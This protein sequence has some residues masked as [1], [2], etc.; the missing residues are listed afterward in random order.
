MFK[1]KSTVISLCVRRLHKRFCG[2]FGYPCSYNVLKIYNSRLY[3]VSIL[4]IYYRKYLKL[5]KFQGF[6]SLA[7]FIYCRLLQII[8]TDIELKMY[9][10][11]YINGLQIEFPLN[12]ATKRTPVVMLNDFLQH[13][14][15]FLYCGLSDF[16][17]VK[18]FINQNRFL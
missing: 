16:K 15:T 18:Y 5:C 12:N 17:I 11:T 8:Y 1:S 13:K 10:W 4:L 9:S 3:Q 14:I 7:D 6:D 2:F